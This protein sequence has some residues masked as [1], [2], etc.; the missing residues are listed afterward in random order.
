VSVIVV[1]YNAGEFLE[2]CVGAV[3]S[4]S[5]PV[6]LLVCDNASDDGS[7]ERMESRYGSDDRLLILRNAS[8]L[9]FARASNRAVKHAKA[10]FVAILNPDCFVEPNTLERLCQVMD[11]NPETGMVG[12]MVRNP[13]GTEQAGT[14]RSIPTPW[15]TLVRVLHLDMLFPRDPKFRNFVITDEPL[16]ESP[17]SMEGI[18]G[19]LMLV[20]GTALENVGLLDEGYFL[21]CED[22]DWF[23][24]FR[25]AGWGILFVPGVEVVHLKGGCSKRHPLRVLW[26]KHRGMV[27]FYRKFFQH[28]YPR[29]LMW[30]VAAAVWARFSLIAAG[31][32]LRASAAHARCWM[33]NLRHVA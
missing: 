23:M 28:Q 25:A 13:D 18:S 14:R 6:Q 15:R 19:A 27:R 4:S 29:P 32:V 3:L 31:T 8:N 17:V 11:A 7:I 24:R 26:H 33:A 20:R 22:L 16:P 10:R 2:D 21:H 5:V 1:S 12:C 30:S 9:G